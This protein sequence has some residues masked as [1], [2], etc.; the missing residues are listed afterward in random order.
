MSVFDVGKYAPSFI[1]TLM[2]QIVT[3]EILVGLFLITLPILFKKNSLANSLN[4]LIAGLLGFRYVRSASLFGLFGLLPLSEKFTVIENE[5]K[6]RTDRYFVN[7]LKGIIFIAT[8]IVVFVYI[9]GLYQYKVL[10]FGYQPYAED[11]TNF[12]NNNN[13]KGPIFNN[14]HIGNYLIYGLYPKEK[15]FIDARPEMYPAPFLQE[16]ERML[17]NQDFFNQ[18]VKRYT[19]NLIVFGV[20]LEDPL[21]IR[22]FILRQIQSKEWIPI[23]ADGNVTVLIKNDPR[24]RDVIE[25]FG[26]KI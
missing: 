14:Y 7:T 18:Q 3:F 5:I 10:H 16:Y 2:L 19:I 4:G 26:M 1:Y 12:I 15:I 20:Q 13:L 11:A 6:K 23:F 21:T 25:K 8:L 17:V 24:S 22:P 9:K